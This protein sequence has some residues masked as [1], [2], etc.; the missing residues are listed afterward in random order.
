LKLNPS[1]KGEGMGSANQYSPS[2][3]W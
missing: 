2:V 1:W 3:F